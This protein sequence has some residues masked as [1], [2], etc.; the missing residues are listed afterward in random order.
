VK[1]QQIIAHLCNKVAKKY[2]EKICLEK[3]TLDIGYFWKNK[4]C[5]IWYSQPSPIDDDGQKG[6][7]I[8]CGKGRQSNIFEGK[9]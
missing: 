9:S 6:G 8:Q 3:N 7:R 2:C 5:R 4:V 1:R